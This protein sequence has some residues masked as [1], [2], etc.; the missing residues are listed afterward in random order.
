M[1]L[2]QILLAPGER[3]NVAVDLPAGDEICCGLLHPGAWSSTWNSDGTSP[4]PG[5]RATATGVEV[6]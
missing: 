5:V 2:V 4:F 3:R 6:F 1:S